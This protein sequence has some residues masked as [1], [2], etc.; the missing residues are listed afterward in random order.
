MTFYVKPKVVELKQSDRIILVVDSCY[1]RT[2][3]KW[4]PLRHIKGGNDDSQ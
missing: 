3:G 1:P 2:W 4:K